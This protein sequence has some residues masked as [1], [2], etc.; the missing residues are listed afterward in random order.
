[1]FE[2]FILIGV[3]FFILIGV[4]RWH[5]AEK[6]KWQL[7]SDELCQKVDVVNEEILGALPLGVV[8]LDIK[9][10]I[11]WHNPLFNKMIGKEKSLKG[12]ISQHLPELALKKHSWFPKWKDSQVA[13]NGRVFHV[14]SNELMHGDDTGRLLLTF[15]DITEQINQGQKYQDDKPV[16]GFIQIDNFNEAIDDV[17]DENK[18]VLLAKIDKILTEW[19]IDME[20]YLRKFA[21]DKYLLV[22]NVGALKEVQENRF[23]IIDR[24]REITLGNKIPVTLSIGIGSG[25]EPIVDLS[26][27][28]Q[29]GLDLALG[30]GGDQVVLKW[31][32][33]VLFYGGKSN[34]VEKRTKVRARVVAYTLKDHIQQASNVIVVGH[35]SSDLDS[36]GASLGVAKAAVEYGKPVHVVLDNSSGALDKLLEVVEE[37]LEYGE[38]IISGWEALQYVNKDTLL[39]IC[40]THKPSLLIESKLLD[41]T[42]K[43][44]IIDHHRR[45]EEFIDKAQLVYLEPYA[46]STSEMVA[47][48]LQYLGE[49]ITLDD[50]TASA[51]LAG[52]A[53][54]TKNFT[55]QTGVRTF[56]AA[57]F[58]RR[59]GA[60]AN[61]V[62]KLLQ[63]DFDTV[64]QRAEIIKQSEVLINNTV[65]GVLPQMVPHA[66]I[67]AAQ[68]ADVL[69]TIEN[70]T[71]S[72]VLY[73][74]PD[75]VN[76]SARSNG[77]L[78]VQVLME[79]L[80]GGGHF[81]VA[82][83]QLKGLSIPEV[84]EKLKTALD[85]HLS[86]I[87][88]DQLSMKR[89]KN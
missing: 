75:G 32:D 70:I 12:K 84:K 45:A 21:E 63:D 56:E 59:A 46:S 20:G 61:M 43:I 67:I 5:L 86:S 79:K 54:D 50:I 13:I 4:W 44:I 47:E 31:P 28:A 81:T 6:K 37:E 38:K 27:L 68:A 87:D 40:D 73:A 23:D 34:T 10:N 18:P 88:N 78:N 62:R 58:L 80:G 17:E 26:R 49:D 9:G 51:L 60:E 64:L 83:A 41:H 3:F 55:F 29:L 52:I 89:L 24:I 57:S 33:K 7:K 48:I 15:Q 65:V 77:D 30:R 53:V 19:A 25:D 1:M 85:E 36:A 39:V 69:L 66:T 72:F 16:V 82:G 74:V 8:V 22:I 11:L 35:E 14:E 71:A 76:I 2:E 42:D